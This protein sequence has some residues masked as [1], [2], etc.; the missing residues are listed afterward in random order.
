MSSLRELVQVMTANETAGG[1]ANL[2]PEEVAELFRSLFDHEP[3][4]DTRTP[5]DVEEQAILEGWS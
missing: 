2:T 5:A 4:V 3:K 1:L